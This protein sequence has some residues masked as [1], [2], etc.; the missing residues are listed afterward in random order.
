MKSRLLEV[1]FIRSHAKEAV[2]QNILIE[3]TEA[4]ILLG[5]VSVDNIAAY[6]GGSSIESSNKIL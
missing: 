4:V 3:G 1:L 6:K 2:C 5:D